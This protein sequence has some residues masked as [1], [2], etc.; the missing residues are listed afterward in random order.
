MATTNDQ[1]E[2]GNKTQS[3]LAYLI[4]ESSPDIIAET[5]I[6]PTGDEF[7]KLPAERQ[8]EELFIL[9]QRLMPLT[10]RIDSMSDSV[11]SLADRM[12]SIEAHQGS[13]KIVKEYCNS[14]IVG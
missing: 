14:F 1:F 8:T 7:K 6:V 9:I 10:K 12:N 4:T 13:Y 5:M 3:T 11:S 2:A